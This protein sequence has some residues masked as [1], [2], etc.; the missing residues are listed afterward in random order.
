[1]SS[2]RLLRELSSEWHMMINFSDIHKL[3]RLVL[4]EYGCDF[5]MI[6]QL[7]VYEVLESFN[8]QMCLLSSVAFLL[9]LL[10]KELVWLR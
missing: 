2:L 3:Q 10:R 1:M 9:V 4:L 6:F 7:M 5:L 8:F